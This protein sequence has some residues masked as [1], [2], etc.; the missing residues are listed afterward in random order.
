MKQSLN[1]SYI[2]VL[3]FQYPA[4]ELVRLLG[5]ESEEHVIAFSAQH[6]LLTDESGNLYFD[7]T[8]FVEPETALTSLRAQLLVESKRT[9]SIGEVRTFFCIYLYSQN[10][11]VST[12]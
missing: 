3:M 11:T 12:K 7:R 8:C 9:N 4:S 1:Q 10:I 5:F 2:I 6:G